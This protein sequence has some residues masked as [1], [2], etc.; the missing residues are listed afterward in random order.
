MLTSSSKLNAR[1]GLP[2][3]KRCSIPT[4]SCKSLPSSYWVLHCC[5]M[6][7]KRK[8]TCSFSHGAG[9]E[10]G[11]LVA[12]VSSYEKE[13]RGRESGFTGTAN[14]N[15]P[16]LGM[17]KKAKVPSKASPITKEDAS[18]RSFSDSSNWCSKYKPSLP[19]LQFVFFVGNSGVESYVCESLKRERELKIEWS[20]AMQ[21]PPR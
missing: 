6:S 16:N 2:S 18:F 8:H 13:E 4:N 10:A 1:T 7:F 11:T 21:T 15:L 9:M 3:E 5:S 12:A 19:A 17:S 14:Q 20:E